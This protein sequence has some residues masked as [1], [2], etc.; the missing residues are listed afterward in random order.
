MWPANDLHQ[1]QGEAGVKLLEI[2]VQEEQE[3]NAYK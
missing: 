1:R 2:S 3:S